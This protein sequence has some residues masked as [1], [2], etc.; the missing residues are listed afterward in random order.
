MG[1]TDQLTQ[2][3]AAWSHPPQ[4]GSEG[5][6]LISYAAPPQEAL[7]TS[8][9]CR[10]SWHTWIEA[11]RHPPRREQRQWR[12]GRPGGVR[13]RAWSASPL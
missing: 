7:P 12:D 5:Q 4:D 2:Q 10:R 11:K 1:N 13:R 9:S 8:S 3:W 6:T